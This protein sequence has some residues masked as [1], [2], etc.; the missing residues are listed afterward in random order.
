MFEFDPKFDWGTVVQFLGFAVAIGVVGYQLHKQRQMQREN[1]LTQIRREIYKEIT[2]RMEQSSPS[3]ISITLDLLLG[4][5]AKARQQKEQTGSYLPPPMRVE[6][7]TND[8]K[9][10]Q[11]RLFAVSGAVEKYEIVGENQPLFRRALVAKIREMSNAFMPIVF[12]LPYILLSDEGIT[13]PDKLLVMTDDELG[14]FRKK[15]EHFRDV[16]ADIDGFLYDI[17]VETQNILL[18]GLFDR[19]LEVRRPLDPEVLVLTSQDTKQLAKVRAFVQR[20]EQLG[21]EDT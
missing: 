8:F 17:Q 14:E 9:G 7:I 10:V 6:T 11:S 15:I 1:H 18:G 21:R 20:S 3:G 5:L 19:K 16:A 12:A 4:L 2:D 13:D